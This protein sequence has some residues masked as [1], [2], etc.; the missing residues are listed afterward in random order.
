[1]RNIVGEVGEPQMEERVTA[2]TDRDAKIGKS[3]M[4]LWMLLGFLLVLWYLLVSR[5]LAFRFEWKLSV[6]F[7]CNA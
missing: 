4:V 7:K 5:K 3:R 6:V 2:K 1:M